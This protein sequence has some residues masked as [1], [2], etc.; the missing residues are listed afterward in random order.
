VSSTAG[1]DDRGQ[2]QDDHWIP[3]LIADLPDQPNA[4]LGDHRVGAESV[5]RE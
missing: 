1:E 5:S 2:P 4:V 3:E